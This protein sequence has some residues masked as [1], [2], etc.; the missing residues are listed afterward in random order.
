MKTIKRNRI[1]CKLCGDII[2]SKSRHD[3]EWCSCESVAVDGGT[4]YTRFIGDPKNY[5]VLT[6]YEE[7]PGCHIV[8]YPHYGGRSEFDVPADKLDIIIENYEGMWYYI[9]ATNENGDEMYKSKGVEKYAN[10]YSDQ[11]S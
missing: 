4:D 7:V 6:E 8:A 2:E 9:V 10:K 3:F 1:R 11:Y 5:E